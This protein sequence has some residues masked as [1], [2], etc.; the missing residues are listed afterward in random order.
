MM[1]HSQGVDM[2]IL[3]GNLLDPEEIS[4][5]LLP[6]QQRKPSMRSCEASPFK[7]QVRV[8]RGGHLEELLRLLVGQTHLIAHS[9]SELQVEVPTQSNHS[10]AS[11]PSPFAMASSPASALEKNAMSHCRWDCLQGCSCGPPGASS[12]PASIVTR[13]LLDPQ[14][15]L[16][17]V[18]ERYAQVMVL[19]FWH[20]GCGQ[21]TKHSVHDHEETDRPFVSLN[22]R[23]HHSVLPDISA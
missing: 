18:R 20:T 4:Y 10:L 9:C 21:H 15:Y 13:L 14:D 5:E 23:I 2:N 1:E 17:V 3:D 16:R 7:V 8:W 11:N 22:Y 6:T 12:A 19:D